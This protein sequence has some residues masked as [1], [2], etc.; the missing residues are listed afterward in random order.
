MILL[1]HFRLLS[2]ACRAVLSAA[3]ML[4]LAQPGGA[5]AQDAAG[6]PQKPIRM[7]VPFP[8]GGYSDVLARLIATDMARS[9]GQPVFVDNRPGAGGNIGADLVAKATP[10]GYTLV[11]GTIGTHAIN[12]ALYPKMPYNPVADFA[13]VAFIADAETVLVV[14]PAVKARSVAQLIA[15]AKAKPGELTYASGGTGTTSHLAGEL[16]KS[17]AGISMVHIPYKGNAPALADLVAGQVSLS[18]ATLQTAL[19]FINAGK[20]VPLAT[21]GKS[22]SAALPVVPTLD[23]S[24]LGGFEVRNWTGIMAPVG[25]PQATAKKLADE[26]DKVMRGADVQAMLAREGL[27]YTAMGPEQFGVFIKAEGAKWARIVRTAG[28]QVD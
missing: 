25:T 21:L 7:I 10:D 12:A 27:R 17:S 22:R 24:G 28:V 18:F 4:T 1:P 14:N 11:V 8:A 9:F 19:P 26:V 13:P 23:E 16:F 15:Q 6:Y 20:L 5:R 2:R 3:V